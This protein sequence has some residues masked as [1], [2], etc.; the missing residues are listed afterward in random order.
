MDSKTDPREKAVAVDSD[1]V[2]QDWGVSVVETVGWDAKATK[3][4]LRKL[5][6]NIIPI[7]SLIYLSV[8]SKDVLRKEDH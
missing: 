5:D 3:R 2:S 8:P 1:N 7:M 4:L 6:W